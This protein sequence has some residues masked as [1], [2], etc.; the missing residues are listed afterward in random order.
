MRALSAAYGFELGDGSPTD[1]WRELCRRF[2]GAHKFIA[3]FATDAG[4]P[5][6]SGLVPPNRDSTLDT[7]VGTRP[8]FLQPRLLPEGVELPVATLFV[9][10]MSRVVRFSYVVP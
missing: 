6:Y 9:L 7:D 4:V 1:L 10:H 5:D 8:T 2:G 3:D